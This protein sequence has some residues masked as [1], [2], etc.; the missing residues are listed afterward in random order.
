MST[1][2]FQLI[3]FITIITI[4]MVALWIYNFLKN[5]KSSF[6]KNSILSDEDLKRL[7]NK[8]EEALIVDR[9][10]LNTLAELNDFSNFIGEANVLVEKFILHKF[11]CDFLSLIAKYRINE[12]CDILQD[13]NSDNITKIEIADV[14]GYSSY[15]LFLVDFDKYA[16][17]ETKNVFEN[18]SE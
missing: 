6:D 2:K 14:V 16:L 13:R 4:F 18:R 11:C 3:T 12:V 17:P 10:Y 15:N 8:I 9:Y 5:N 1:L 7:S